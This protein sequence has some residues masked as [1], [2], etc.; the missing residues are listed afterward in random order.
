VTPKAKKVK[1][2]GIVP[3]AR[4]VSVMVGTSAE[5]I[6]A[7]QEQDA[8]L[9]EL[10]I[11][12][13][14]MALAT[15]LQ[16]QWARPMTNY[17]GRIAHALEARNEAEGSGFGV[18]GL[19]LGNKKG[20]GKEKGEDENA[21]NGNRNGDGDEDRDGDGDSEQDVDGDETMGKSL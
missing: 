15:S 9:N 11:F 17:L 20:K 14:K 13:E 6:D 18:L 7:I 5:I 12:Q 10:L 2:S 16:A 8:L 4:P 21:E 19:G 3:K 1:T